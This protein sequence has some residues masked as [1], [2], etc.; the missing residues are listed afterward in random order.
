MPLCTTTTPRSPRTEGHLI[1]WTEGHLID[2]FTVLYP[3][4]FPQDARWGAGGTQC[5][6]VSLR[7]GF[8]C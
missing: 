5:S 4:S 8:I 1:D 6:L 7:P 2:T 3:A